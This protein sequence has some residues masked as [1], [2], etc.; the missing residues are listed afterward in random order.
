MS[1]IL[2]FFIGGLFGILIICLF[3]ALPKGG[4]D[5]DF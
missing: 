4:L 1:F 5:E 3:V 2:G